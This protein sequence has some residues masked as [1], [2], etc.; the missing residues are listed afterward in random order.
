MKYHSSGPSHIELVGKKNNSG[1]IPPHFYYR[2]VVYTLRRFTGIRN[3]GGHLSHMA[4][5]L[6]KHC[7]ASSGIDKEQNSAIRMDN[8]DFDA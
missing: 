3:K 4:R 7:R 8:S 1:V 5:N 2:N 6:F